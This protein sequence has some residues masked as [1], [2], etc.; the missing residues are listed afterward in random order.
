LSAAFTSFGRERKSADQSA[1]SKTWRQVPRFIGGGTK[2]DRTRAFPLEKNLANNIDTDFYHQAAW[3]W[4]ALVEIVGDEGVA[5]LFTAWARARI[6]PLDPGAAIRPAF[7]A[8][9]DAERPAAWWSR[10]EPVL[11]HKTERSDFPV[12]KGNAGIVSEHPNPMSGLALWPVDP[13]DRS[14]QAVAEVGAGVR[15]L[16]TFARFRRGLSLVTSAATREGVSE[17]AADRADSLT[18]GC[19]RSAAP[20][21]HNTTNFRH[22]KPL[23][24]CIRHERII[25]AN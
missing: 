19:P 11:I 2:S 9:P 20:L 6:D 5:P 14:S 24:R 8:R 3:A 12:T 23:E 16:W 13:R 25:C 22:S 4:K 10:S 21:Q 1:H 17:R 7:S 15:R 18:E